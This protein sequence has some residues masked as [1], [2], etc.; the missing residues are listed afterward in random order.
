MNGLLS[1]ATMAQ[2]WPLFRYDYRN[3]YEIR[4]LFLSSFFALESLVKTLFNC[5]NRF[6]Q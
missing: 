2:E 3:C 6:N 4:S 1:K 5:F